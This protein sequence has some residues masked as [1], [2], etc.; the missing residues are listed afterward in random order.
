MASKRDSYEGLRR[1]PLRTFTKHAEQ[2]ILDRVSLEKVIEAVENGH[3]SPE[4]RDKYRAVLPV[5]DGKLLVVIFRDW[6]EYLVLL[7][8]TLTGGSRR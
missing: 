7:T 6:G 2:R 4:G 8:V 1:K 5:K 3:I